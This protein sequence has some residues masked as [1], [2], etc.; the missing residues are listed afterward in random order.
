MKSISFLAVALL[1]TAAPL[2]SAKDCCGQSR[3]QPCG[4]NRVIATQ[5]YKAKDG[6]LREKVPYWQALS[7]AEDADDMEIELRGVQEELAAA[8]ETATTQ[9]AEIAALRQQ[10]EEQVAATA[11]ATERANKAEASVAELTAALEKSVA[12]AGAAATARDE[13]KA[14]LAMATEQVSNLTAERE[15]MV[16]EIANATSEIERLKQEAVES[17]KVAVATEDY[18]ADPQ[19]GDEP[20]EETPVEEEPAEEPKAE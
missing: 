18:D 12:E 19:E 13:A 17:K 9:D 2:A 6:T 1:I 10:L 14:A 15:K 5:W 3:C 20:K 11:A 16:A 7:R 8:T 4:G